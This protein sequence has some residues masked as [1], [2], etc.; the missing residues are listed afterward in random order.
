LL[1]KQQ[2]RQCG[3]SFLSDWQSVSTL[4]FQGNS[5]DGIL[6]DFFIE[7]LVTHKLL[8]TSLAESVRVQNLEKFLELVYR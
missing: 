6:L 4:S 1:Y 8:H 3:A 2:E 7:V 5:V